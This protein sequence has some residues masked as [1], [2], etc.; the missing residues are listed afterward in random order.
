MGDTGCYGP[1]VITVRHCEV[2]EDIKTQAEGFRIEPR[3]PS[4]KAGD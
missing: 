1:F 2:P 3:P 4:R